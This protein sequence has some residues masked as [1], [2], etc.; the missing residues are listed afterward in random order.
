MTKF[1]YNDISIVTDNAYKI[2]EA[3]KGEHY[4]DVLYYEFHEPV[5]PDGIF[6]C[7]EGL[8]HFKNASRKFNDFFLYHAF[9]DSFPAVIHIVIKVSNEWFVAQNCGANYYTGYGPCGII[10]LREACSNKKIIGLVIE[11]NIK[12]WIKEKFNNE[13]KNDERIQFLSIIESLRYLSIEMQRKPSNFKLLNEENIRDHLLTYINGAFSGRGNA[14]AK[15]NKGKTD[16]LVRTKD[17]LNEHI[18]E[19]KIWKGIISLKNALEQLKG[20]LSW[21]NNHTGL[22]ILCYNK[23]FSQIL[24]KSEKYLNNHFELNER[25]KKTPNELIIN[26]QHNTDNYKTIECRIMF[27]NLC[28]S[29]NN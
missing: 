19:L 29:D 6:N 9:V 20:Y 4:S 27:V 8:E 7:L 28:I 12:D 11:E 23:N 26:I 14:E 25:N 17:G 18:F 2:A 10:K 5:N 22:I 1:N 21:H 15:N 16:I 13:I 3:I 24:Q